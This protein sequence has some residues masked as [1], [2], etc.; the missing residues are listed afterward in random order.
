MTSEIKVNKVSDSCGS[1]LVTKCGSNITIGAS[2]KNILLACGANQT[3]FGRSGSV[4][5]CT[6]AKT[7]P[8]TGVSGKGY[9]VNT[10]SGAV[11]VTLPSSPSAGA[12]ISVKDYANTFDSNNLTIGRGGSKLSGGC[13]DAVLNTKGDSLTLVYVDA[14][15]GWL[16]VQTDDT[17]KGAP[18]FISATGG[19]ITTSGDF[20][21]HT[22]TSDGTFS[23]DSAPTPSNN[24]ISYL[25]IAGG[26]GSGSSSGNSAGGGGAGGFREGKTPA[27]PYTA[28][29]LVAPA[30]LPVSVTSYPV[31]VG[32]G[33]G[34]APGNP[35]PGPETAGTQ[36]STST[37]SSVSSAGGGFGGGP[38]EN[39][40][41]GG[42]GGSGGGAGGGGFNRPG[43]SGNTPPVSPPQ[44]NN[45]GNSPSPSPSGLDS[46]GGGGGGAGA[47]GTQAAGP[48]GGGPGGAGVSTEI[49]G[50]AVTRAGGGGGGAYSHPSAPSS[51]GGTGG[52]GGG[53]DAG[54]PSPSA[55]TNG[56]ANTGGGGG[57]PSSGASF[58]GT[59]GGSG[60]VII[61]YKY[62]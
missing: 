37:F 25:V 32:A 38:N 27:T 49:S 18:N 26:G 58:A 62:Q 61:R 46:Q 12:I 29:P 5:W 57:A 20:K 15:Q 6:T 52:A 56:T 9:F 1:A 51:N 14:T 50:S 3:G 53:G 43:G 39:S 36:G 33:G 2:G 59:T 19:T 54:R 16:N 24:N 41:T 45:G 42:S 30:G 13:L 48:T 47:V 28:S 17:V 40:G 11:T 22:F 21:I 60:I 7:S 10:T 44:G 35:G 23:V 55:G 31:T 8:F 34:G 4:D